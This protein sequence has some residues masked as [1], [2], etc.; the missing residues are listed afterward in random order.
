MVLVKCQ[1]EATGIHRHTR[2]T[3]TYIQLT[4]CA[5]VSTASLGCVPEPEYMED[6]V[7]FDMGAATR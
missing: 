7:K 2:H 6:I 4:K 5:S 1:G 3:R